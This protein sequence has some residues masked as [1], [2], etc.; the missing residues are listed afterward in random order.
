M[1]RFQGRM[2]RFQG[3]MTKDDPKLDTAP[4]THEVMSACESLLLWR[5]YAGLLPGCA[6]RPDGSAAVAGGGGAVRTSAPTCFSGTATA[7]KKNS[8]SVH[9]LW[10]CVLRQVCGVDRRQSALAIC[11]FRHVASAERR[12]QESER[13]LEQP[14]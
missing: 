1:K 3:R 13:I 14:I 2:K 10:H 4:R 12:M 7:V 9:A 6:Q 11:C 5:L 8:S